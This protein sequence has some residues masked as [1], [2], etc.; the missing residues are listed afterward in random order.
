MHTDPSRRDPRGLTGGVLQRPVSA[1]A[2]SPARR[3]IYFRKIKL[4]SKFRTSLTLRPCAT[5]TTGK[6]ERRMWG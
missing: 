1:C 6:A 2:A 4:K 5:K 3:G